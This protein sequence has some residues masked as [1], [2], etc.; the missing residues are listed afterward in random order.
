MYKIVS[1]WNDISCVKVVAYPGILFGLEGS[2][3]SVD[4]RGQRERGSG[5]GS[6]I[7]RG[8]GGSCNLVQKFSFHTVKFS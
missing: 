7:D 4:D 5:G 1:V 3:N 2:R 8:Y 6:P